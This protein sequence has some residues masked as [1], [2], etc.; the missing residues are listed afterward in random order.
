M[1]VQVVI[2]QN[3]VPLASP[4]DNERQDSIDGRGNQERRRNADRIGS[5]A[6]AGE[7]KGR[8]RQRHEPPAARGGAHSHRRGGAGRWA[9]AREWWT[10][11]RARASIS[12]VATSLESLAES[13]LSLCPG[14]SPPHRATLG[15]A[16]GGRA[17]GRGKPWQAPRAHD[18]VPALRRARWGAQL[19]R[20][21]SS[22]LRLERHAWRGGLCVSGSALRGVGEALAAR[23]PTQRLRRHSRRS[24]IACAAALTPSGSCAQRR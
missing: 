24:Q 17:G 3:G 16:E 4:H 20:A 12:L 11:E 22:A 23:N 1:R 13:S 7:D 2:G 21:W 15:G 6:N 10:S 19:L 8:S 18:V 5:A 14:A 9:L